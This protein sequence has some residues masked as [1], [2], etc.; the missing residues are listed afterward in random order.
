MKRVLSK[1][2]HK[3]SS[4]YY[5]LQLKTMLNYCKKRKTLSYATFA[6]ENECS[7]FPRALYLICSQQTNALQ[8]RKGSHN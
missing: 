1:F 4:K 6:T 7:V 8:H 3:S 2:L 5:R